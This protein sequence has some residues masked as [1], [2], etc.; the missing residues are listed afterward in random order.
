MEYHVVHNNMKKIRIYHNNESTVVEIPQFSDG[1]YMAVLYD[2]LKAK[3]KQ[4]HCK[5]G[6]ELPIPYFQIESVET[7]LVCHFCH[8]GYVCLAETKQLDNVKSLITRIKNIPVC[9]HSPQYTFNTLSRPVSCNGTFQSCSNCLHLFE[10]DN[11]QCHKCNMTVYTK[12]EHVKDG[13]VYC[14]SVCKSRN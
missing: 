12:F 13:Y 11:I 7:E 9:E 4:I 14:S 3:E 5:C 6:I 10:N 8:M 1:D 2:E